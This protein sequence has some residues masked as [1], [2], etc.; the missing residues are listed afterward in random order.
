M[1][2][3]SKL[4]ALQK[5]LGQKKKVSTCP[6]SPLGL[7]IWKKLMSGILSG[8]LEQG[9]RYWS[10]RGEGEAGEGKEGRRRLCRSERT[11]A[12]QEDQ[13]DWKLCP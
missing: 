10:A 6:G 4:N 2:V 1:Q 11:R 7:Y 13:D 5:E 3:G 12:R 8:N 9:G